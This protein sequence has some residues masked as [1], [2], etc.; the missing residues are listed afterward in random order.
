[1]FLLFA[2]FTSCGWE[3][4][5]AGLAGPEHVV[6]KPKTRGITVMSFNIFGARG[7]DI[8]AE[9]DALA[10][11]IRY[12]NPDFVLLQEVDSCTLRQGNIPC[13]S[14]ARLAEILD[15]TTV[16]K[17]H[18]N[19]S[20]A[21]YNL[22]NQGGAYG[23]AIL[24][25]HPILWEKDYRLDYAEEHENQKEKEKRSVCVIKSLVDT[26]EVYIGCTHFDHLYTEHSR[27]SQAHQLRTIVEEYEGE[28][29]ILGGDL[30]SKPDSETMSIV[31][32]YLTPSYTDPKQYT[33]PSQMKG[34]PSSMIDYVML[35]NY[36]K[37]IMCTSSNV[38]DTAS[39]DHCAV[40]ATYVFTEE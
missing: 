9:Y 15:T 35:A 26:T 8:D 40:Y 19:F 38:I 6:I 2:V 23:D 33:Y 17:W 11:V 39:S 30:N 20:P 7:L 22:Y 31:T 13:N 3:D 14:A 24:S 28:I 27:I 12:V 21:E 16:Y 10:S 1:M 5:L 25:R 18:Y 29:L 37:G 36:S 32:E 34:V 4:P